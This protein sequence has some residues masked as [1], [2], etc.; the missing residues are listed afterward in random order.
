[1]PRCGA[2]TTSEAPIHSA[3]PHQK[4]DNA[5]QLTGEPSENG[6]RQENQLFE[7]AEI[8]RRSHLNCI[9]VEMHE[10]SSCPAR[11]VSK[12]KSHLSVNC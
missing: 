9:V 4:S 10:R 7:F 11:K 1:M 8:Q 3:P 6:N 12:A 2:M 5:I